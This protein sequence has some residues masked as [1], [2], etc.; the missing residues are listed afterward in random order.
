M[1]ALH[2]PMVHVA[3]AECLE[4]ADINRLIE[5][6][7]QIQSVLL[8]YLRIRRLRKLQQL[9]RAQEAAHYARAAALRIRLGDIEA[10]IDHLF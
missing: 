5:V 2:I 7:Q 1:D 8:D 4:F 6:D 3:I 9:L 10:R